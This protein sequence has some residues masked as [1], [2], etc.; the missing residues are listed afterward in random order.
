MSSKYVDEEDRDNVDEGKSPD[1]KDSG[2]G[3]G[4]KTADN[5]VE[6]T[7]EVVIDP[8]KPQSP[9]LVQRF[10]EFAFSML[11]TKMD[12]FFERHA[13]K[14]DQEWDDYLQSGETLEQYE[15]FKEY[16]ELLD[17]NLTEFVH[18]EGFKSVG[19]CFNEI[20]NLIEEDKAK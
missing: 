14:F 5:E 12:S 7:S 2:S 19:A 6:A 18:K 8:F 3:G 17:E 11:H 1:K 20:S 16:E 15:I 4:G 10:V 13:A 9:N